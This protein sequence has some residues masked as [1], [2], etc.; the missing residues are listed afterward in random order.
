MIV[1]WIF[2]KYIFWFPKIA[3][4]L[5]VWY[6]LGAIG[7]PFLIAVVDICTRYDKGDIFKLPNYYE[8]ADGS[9]FAGFVITMIVY[10][11]IFMLNLSLFYVYMI[12][13]HMDGRF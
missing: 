12:L 5:I 13:H 7:D 6:G 9:G 11:F 1:T 2:N 10:T 3:S 4:K 8:K